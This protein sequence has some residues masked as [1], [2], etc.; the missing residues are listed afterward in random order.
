M[1]AT[2]VKKSYPETAESGQF[3][4]STMLDMDTRLRVARAIGKDETQASIG[5]FQILKRR[6]HPAG[7]PPTL[8]D[9]WGGIDEAMVEVYGLVPEYAGRGRPPTRKK[10]GSDWLYLQMVKQRDEHGRFQG[11]KLRVVFGSK[12]EVVALLGKSTAYIERNHLTS[13][14]FNSRQVRKTLAFSKDVAMYQ[15]AVTWEDSYYNL[16]R[17]H[18]SLRY[19]VQ[20][21]LPQKWQQRTPA[22]AAHLT[23]HIWTVKE[24]LTTLPLPRVTN[25]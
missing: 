16:I 7:P 24:L 9:G 22:M 19:P 17:P 15:A 11:T 13:R 21:A 3:M 23:D 14:L 1:C 18:K 20:E 4:R 12:A 5:V 6:G 8:S 25:T 2:K 10:P